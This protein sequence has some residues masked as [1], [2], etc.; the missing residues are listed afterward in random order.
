MPATVGTTPI[1]ARSFD[2][3]LA[4]AASFHGHMCPG[5]VLGVRMTLAGCRAVGVD[6]PRAA[7]KSFVV[8]AEIDRCATDAIEAL[9]SVSLGK[10]TLKYVDFGKMAA[11]FVNRATGASARVAAREDA[12][13]RAMRLAPA[14]RDP[15]QAQMLAYRVMTES[16]LL[17]VTPVTV[18]PELLERRRVRV[19]CQA[20]GEGVNYEREVQR[21]GLVVCR[22]CAGDA[23]Y[24]IDAGR[25]E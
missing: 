8:I 16:D 14:E 18:N 1:H 11:T 10:R 23:Y 9:T 19:E 12:R 7:R 22:G 3:L 5:Q 24:R 4:E 21:D 17:T 20:C 2:D 13:L 6:D 25:P 15:R